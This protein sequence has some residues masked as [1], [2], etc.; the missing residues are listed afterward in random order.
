MLWLVAE[1]RRGD[2]CTIYTFWQIPLKHHN[3]PNL[4]QFVSYVVHLDLYSRS[5]IVALTIRLPQG[6]RVFVGAELRQY[7]VGLS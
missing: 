3:L 2:Y 5:I 7:K 4:G 1:L 6:G